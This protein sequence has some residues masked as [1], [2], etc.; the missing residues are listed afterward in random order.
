MEDRNTEFDG[1]SQVIT[2]ERKEGQLTISEI[3][4]NI[5]RAANDC[6]KSTWRYIVIWVDLDRDGGGAVEG[7]G[8]GRA[9]IVTITIVI[10]TIPWWGAAVTLRGGAVIDFNPVVARSYMSQM[11]Y[12]GQSDRENVT[13]FT[14]F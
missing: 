7:A 5:H 3:G 12:A 11:L 9:E 8:D 6:L 13:F 10:I 1:V 4:G 14:D 2:I